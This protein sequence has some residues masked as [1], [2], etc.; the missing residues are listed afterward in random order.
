MVFEIFELLLRN[1]FRKIFIWCYRMKKTCTM[2]V[3]SRSLTNESAQRKCNNFTKHSTISIHCLI[4]TNWYIPI[5]RN[6]ESLD[7]LAN[8]SNGPSRSSGASK[9]GAC[10][11]SAQKFVFLFWFSLRYFL[12]D[13]WT[14]DVYEHNDSIELN[15]IR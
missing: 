13:S 9:T 14:R 4:H 3:H 12:I 10:D 15:R 2:N 8:F 7:F 11:I 5:G 6:G 1:C